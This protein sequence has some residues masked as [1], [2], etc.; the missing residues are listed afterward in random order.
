MSAR[1]PFMKRLGRAWEELLGS[2]G[3]S[4]IYKGAE[5]SRLTADWNP[6]LLAPDEETRWTAMRM[7][8]RGRDL[9]RNNAYVRQYL[10]LLAVNVIGARGMTHEAMVRNNDGRLNQLFNERLEDG[11]DEYSQR[12]TLDGRL[13]RVALEQQSI[14]GVARDGEVLIR[15]WRGGPDDFP[16][17]RFGLALEAIDP[18]L[19]DERYIR[20]ASSGNNEI[21]MGVEVDS[22]GRPVAYHV[23]DKPW[24][25]AGSSAARKRLRIPA[26]DIIHLYTQERPNQTRGI[27]W[28]SPIMLPVR[29]LGGYTEAELVAAR[30]SASK[31]GW[32]MPKE[33]EGGF[34][35]DDN[36]KSID[37]EANP[38]G[39]DFGP[40]GHTFEAWDPTH[41][42]TAFGDFVK[43]ALREVATGLG[44]DYNTL[45]N[46]LENVNYSS[47]RSG[48]LI[49]RDVWRMKQQWWIDTFERRVYIE[50][51]NMA[52]LNGALKLDARDARKFSAVRF[53]PRGWPWVDPLKDVQAGL[54][55]I[56]AG[57]ASRTQ[58]MGEQGVDLED[59][60]EDLADENDLAE[61]FGIDISIDKPAAMKSAAATTQA[62][63]KEAAAQEAAAAGDGSSADGANGTAGRKAAMNGHVPDGRSRPRPRREV[64]KAFLNGTQHKE[65]NS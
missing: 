25:I 53:T 50:W 27:T 46:D 22:R 16:G 33:G 18:D 15:I 34:S 51:L 31:M 24:G 36:T 6:T 64:I 32:F 17:N 13:S 49:S 1:R 47:M 58:L 23:W 20:A 5:S 54:L 52:L 63:E 62:E 65:V 39:L 42:N 19:L 41:P 21:R 11:W 2:G 61:Q 60:L 9:A 4:S 35:P 10:N 14:Q 57:L 56:S 43:S 45:A 55:A 44:I 7:R 30:I 38:G 29:M 48:L 3:G 40:A 59:T 28:F 12:V 37:L 8:A 26:D